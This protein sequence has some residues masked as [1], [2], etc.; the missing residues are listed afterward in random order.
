M[1]EVVNSCEKKEHIIICDILHTHTLIHREV[2]IPE[3]TRVCIYTSNSTKIF[4]T[5][6]LTSTYICTLSEIYTYV[7]IYRHD[8][9][10]N[11]TH[12]C[13]HAQCHTHKQRGN[14]T[15]TRAITHAQCY[16]Y[17]PPHTHTETYITYT[18]MRT[19]KHIN[20]LKQELKLMDPRS[21][22]THNYL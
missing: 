20:F 13:R 1:K 21:I 2:G 4:R 7:Q 11:Y 5:L 6:S 8:R 10:Q 22:C 14:Y 15:H 18:H 9:A 12:M 19:H 16:I 3:D 17:A